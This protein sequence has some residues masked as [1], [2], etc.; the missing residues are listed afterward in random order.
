M[1]PCEGGQ[2]C[3]SPPCLPAVAPERV[4]LNG[5]MFGEILELDSEVLMSLGLVLVCPGAFSPSD[6]TPVAFLH[7]HS[8][9]GN[10]KPRLHQGFHLQAIGGLIFSSPCRR[11][12]VLTTFDGPWLSC[13]AEVNPQGRILQTL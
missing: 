6:V 9:V 12:V 7:P 5:N 2:A 10:F 1:F 4:T 13:A 11:W 8:F 3:F